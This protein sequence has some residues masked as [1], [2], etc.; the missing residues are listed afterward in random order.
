MESG[1]IYFID[2]PMSDGHEQHGDRPAIIVVDFPNLPIAQVVPLT[3]RKKAQTYGSLVVKIEPD[4]TNN[5]KE[6]SYA[7]LFQTRAIDKKRLKNRKGKLSNDDFTRLL[8]GIR[9]MFSL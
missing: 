3:T 4:T 2:F 1:E 6:T 5:L 9:N 7:L 8:N